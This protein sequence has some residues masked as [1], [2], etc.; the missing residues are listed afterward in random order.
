MRAILWDR[1]RARV[2]LAYLH[3]MLVVLIV[4]LGV[5][6]VWGHLAL[7]N[8]NEV[9]Q[10][11]T[12]RLEL[13]SRLQ[14]EMRALIFPV[15]T[16]LVMGDPGARTSFDGAMEKARATLAE[17]EQGCRTLD[18]RMEV[19]NLG[20]LLDSIGRTAADLFDVENPVAN[21]DTRAGMLQVQY[22]MITTEDMLARFLSK[23][24]EEVEK[25]SRRS[26]A[27]MRMALWVTVVVTV[28]GALLSTL[29]FYSLI[30][31]PVGRL[32]RRARYLAA[33]DLRRDVPLLG[34]GEVFSLSQSLGLMARNLRQVLLEAAEKADQTTRTASEL[35]AGAENAASGT[36]QI[37]RGIQEVA[38]G[39]SEQTRHAS[40]TA[41]AVA[42]LKAAI[43][44]VAA[45]AQEQARNVETVSSLMSDM[46]RLMD[47]VGEAARAVQASS[48]SA[49]VS[50]EKGYA[51]VHRMVQAMD[52]IRAT[53][54]T[55]A[56]KMEELGAHS[57]RI[58]E[59]VEVIDEIA[60]QTNLLALNAAIEAA[61]AGEHGRGF[62]VVA[63][64]V[65]KLAERSSR[66]TKEIAGLI[67]SVQKETRGTAA[68]MESAMKEVEQG[69]DVAQG[70]RDALEDIRR[71][72]A[73]SDEQAEGVA[74]AAER[75]LAHSQQVA[76][77]VDAL[78][79]ATE[80]NAA[81]T[82]QMAQGSER[83]AQAAAGIAAISEQNAAAAEEVSAAVEE[84]NAVVEQVAGWA[85]TLAEIAE[86]HRRL[87]SH[88][89]LVGDGS[90]PATGTPAMVA[91]SPA[92]AAGGQAGVAG[93]PTGAEAAPP[94]VEGRPGTGA[95]APAATGAPPA[96]APASGS[97]G[98][99]W[100]RRLLGGM[101]SKVVG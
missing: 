83:V 15:T 42:Q 69:M 55:L 50:V 4:L 24:D 53:G 45:G 9:R 44:Q 59:I 57:E 23:Y 62:A 60:D 22:S 77:A 54:G 30:L 81:A 33:G 71:Q 5:S 36:G 80:E 47:E 37:T 66:A 76:R 38:R 92:A 41:S 7:R 61:R 43:A 51:A 88:F 95:E 68:S 97:R 11:A 75:M 46:V 18:E 89:Q 17:M 26:E 65:R 20:N 29:G 31:R 70:V 64:E 2:S 27:F 21:P 35:K 72:V 12:A 14:S 73:D 16:W 79:A 6:A 93:S 3:V 25:A 91:A 84:V 1:V 52:R 96:A 78:A 99:R 98:G 86:E 28:G 85:R 39:A 67:A 34:G 40:E 32:S 63:D 10:E 58:S 56:A 82:E 74:R 13:A 94:V 87:S 101:R 48:A 8:A 19:R 90:G 49:S 100:L